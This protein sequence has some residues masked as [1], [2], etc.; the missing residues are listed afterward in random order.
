MATTYTLTRVAPFGAI[1]IHR[2][3]TAVDKAIASLSAWNDTRHSLAAL[4]RLDA[5]LL[6][7]IG[8]TRSDI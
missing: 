2:V 4:R 5:H 8:L 6:D 1:T 7:D 3:A